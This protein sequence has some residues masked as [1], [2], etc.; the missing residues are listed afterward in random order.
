MQHGHKNY[1]DQNSLFPVFLKLEKLKV[2]L[3]GGGN[4]GVEK[5][6]AL[7]RN[8]PQTKVHVIALAIDERIKGMQKAHPAITTEI[9]EYNATDLDGY[10]LIFSA[11][12]DQSLSAQI[13]ADAKARDIL[14]NVADKPELCDFY[15]SSIAAKGSLKIAISTNGK[16]PTFAKRLKEIIYDAIPD[17]TE[18]TLDNLDEIRSKLNVNFSD[19]VQRL[20]KITSELAVNPNLEI[21]EIN[22]TIKW[23]TIAWLSLGA[24]V[25]MIVGYILFSYIPVKELGEEITVLTSTLDKAFYWMILVGF[26]AQMVDGA[27]GMGYGVTS[28]AA[29]LSIGVPLPAISGSIHTAEMFSSGASGFS[30]YK[31]GNIN[32]KLLKLLIIPGVLGSVAGAILLSKLGITYANIVKPILA[33]YTMIL[34]IRILYNAFKKSRKK[35][36]VKRVGW[37]ALAGGFLDSFGGGGWGPL[38]TSTLISKGKTPRYVIGTVSLSEFFVTFASAITF[39][40]F[41]GLSHWQVILG[42]IIGGLI[43][44]PLAARLAGKLPLKT[45]FI[46]VGTLVIIWSLNILFKTIF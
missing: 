16:S 31:F 21:E 7:I 36:K 41:L 19:K 1:A 12:N 13:A 35:K 23:K 42:L 3:I 30:H 6:S 5:L 45:M 25:F 33:C 26:L 24:F 8:S 44:A 17:S 15:L 38:V 20:N 11:V 28:T 46:G 9:K 18:D 4:V 39:F 22:S 34:G 10:D 32:K 43:A 27:L 2:L 14:I 40:T 37:L 29:L